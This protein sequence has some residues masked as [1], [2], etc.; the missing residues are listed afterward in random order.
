MDVHETQLPGIGS[1]FTIRFEQ[2]GE[3]IVLLHNEGNQDVFWRADPDDDSQKLYSVTERQARKLAEIFDGTYFEPVASDDLEEVWEDAVVEWV[4][5]DSDS[6]AVGKS[7]RGLGIRTRTGVTV[8]AVQRGT[9][10]IANPDADLQMESGD[11]LVT[12]GTEDAHESFEQLLRS[13]GSS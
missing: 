5:I 8:I 10:T 13:G 12:V 2:G 6:V 7:I 9:E 4:E 11:V 1:R 3:L